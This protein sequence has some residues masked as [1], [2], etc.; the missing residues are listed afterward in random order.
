M[1]NFGENS[2]GKFCTETVIMT[3]LVLI[4]VICHWWTCLFSS[5]WS[6]VSLCQ[7]QCMPSCY[8]S[9]TDVVCAWMAVCGSPM[10]E[11]ICIQHMKC[12]FFRASLHYYMLHIETTWILMHEMYDLV[13][14]GRVSLS[15]LL[16]CLFVTLMWHTKHRTHIFKDSIHWGI[17]WK[18]GLTHHHCSTQFVINSRASCQ[19]HIDYW[20]C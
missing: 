8:L 5:V 10:F 7:L 20:M 15:I 16:W 9:I 14:I 4:G 19:S 12:L 13:I 6:L 11:C 17:N 1:M 3:M 18:V 2:W